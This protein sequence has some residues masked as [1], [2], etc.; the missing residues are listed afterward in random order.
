[1]P[2][3]LKFYLDEHVDRAVADGLYR[4]GVD[5]LR[6]QDAGMHPAPD[7]AHL[8]LAR[9]EGRVIFTQDADFLRLHAAGEPHASIVYAPQ[10]T[11]VGTIVR[12]LMLIYEV[13]P[14]EEMINHIE[15]V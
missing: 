5:V 10:H 12:S 13:I 9:H 3:R 11:A 14:P 1:M 8:D 15:F 7:S 2:E 4:R 6:A